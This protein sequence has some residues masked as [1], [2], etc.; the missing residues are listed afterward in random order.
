[1]S[2]GPEIIVV[3]GG[4]LGASAAGALAARGARVTVL[5]AVTPGSGASS[6]SFAWV[7]A[8]KKR[9]DPYF[10]LNLAGIEEYH[11]LAEAGVARGWFHPVG[12]LEIAT[13]PASAAALDLV[14]DDLAIHDYPARRITAAEAAELEP[15]VDP[16]RIEDAAFFARE[17]WVDAELMIARMLAL[18][19]ADGGRIRPYTPVDRIEQ[20]GARLTVFLA[21]G[22]RLSADHVVCAAGGATQGLLE[23][24]GVRVP[25]IEETRTRLRA[26][27]D[28]RYPV[29]G[30]LADTTPLRTP[31]RRVLHTPDMGLRPTASGRVVLGGDGAGSRVARS[32]Y[33]VFANGPRLL[34]QA[35]KIFPSFA[36]VRLDRVRVGLRPMP[37]DGLTVAGRPAALPGVY[38]LA[39]HSGI[40]LAQ[41]LARLTA[42]ELLDAEQHP[43]LAD[44]RPDRF[45]KAEA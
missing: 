18:V 10:R 22:D 16:E 41:Y 38:V 31:L 8:H 1:V 39:T 19:L 5:D 27:G 17:G 45:L 40:T 4:V 28:E 2:K 24:S 34:E 30:G 21:N 6:A 42:I 23:R 13:E 43:A 25:M 3:G 36:D 35:K 12:N 15:A 32:D 11:R 20:A 37:E 44:F 9:P 14:V 7:N 33:A 29:V 26:P